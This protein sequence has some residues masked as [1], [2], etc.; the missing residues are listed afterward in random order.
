MSWLSLLGIWAGLISANVVQDLAVDYGAAR[1]WLLDVDVE[2]SLY[3]WFSQLLLALVA[4]LLFDT[5]AKMR[6]AERFVAS[7]WLALSAIFVL[8]SIDEALSLHEIASQRLS[9]AIPTSGFLMFAWVVPAAVVCLLGLAAATPF[10]LRLPGRVR[11][12]MLLSAVLFLGGAVGME[13]VGGKILS[14]FGGDASVLPYRWAVA[15]EEGLEGLG[16]LVFLYSHLLYRRTEALRPL[17][18]Q[19]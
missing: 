6:R 7:Q 15:V 13:M 11:M 3:T 10:L 16:V 4:L 18:Q 19:V 8:L 9:E 17:L 1:I 12:L 2:R 14:D 5:G